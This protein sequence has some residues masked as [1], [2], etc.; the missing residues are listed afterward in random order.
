VTEADVEVSAPA[1]EDRVPYE[2]DSTRSVSFTQAFQI[3]K[4]LPTPLK[5]VTLEVR[6]EG[7]LI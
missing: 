2:K 3:K 7:K 6:M 4:F 1:K 5:G